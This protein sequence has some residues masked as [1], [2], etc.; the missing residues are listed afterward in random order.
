MISLQSS[1]QGYYTR[2]VNY[3]AAEVE[4]LLVRRP[5]MIAQV[6]PGVSIRVQS[7]PEGL[8]DDHP[9][10]CHTNVL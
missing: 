5:A 2:I 1:V 4:G 3:S 10:K 6:S 8:V 7:V 9:V